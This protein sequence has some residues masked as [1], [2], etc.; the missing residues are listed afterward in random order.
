M[1]IFCRELN[2]E[3]PSKEEMFTALKENVDRIKA[4]KKATIKESDPIGFEMKIVKADG[5]VEK[6]EGDNVEVKNG[7]TIYPIINTTNILDSH[8]DVHLDGIW[9]NSVKDQ[10]GKVHYAVNHKLEIGTIV[11]FPD[12]VVM[13]VQSMPWSDLKQPYQGNTQALVFAAKVTDA[14][15]KDAKKMIKAKKPVQNS[16]RMQY[17]DMDLC[18]DSNSKGMEQERMNYYMHLPKIVNSDQAKEQG[19][20]WAVKQAKIVKEGSMVLAG[21]NPAT[22]I[23]Y[24][25]PAVAGQKEHQSPS[26]DSVDKSDYFYNI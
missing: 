24:T 26:D 8:G 19:Y 20:F 16:V 3:F 14:S 21:S 2:K 18:M 9:D 7:D 4:L 13:S 12:E 5:S 23:S 1:K 25:D 15:N 11:S 22:P 10:Q 6:A 17:V